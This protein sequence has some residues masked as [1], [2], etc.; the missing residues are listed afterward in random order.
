MSFAIKP[1]D[2]LASGIAAGRRIADCITKLSAQDSG[3]LA[4]EKTLDAPRLPILQWV[5]PPPTN[6]LEPTPEDKDDRLLDVKQSE[7]VRQTNR[8]RE[9]GLS[10]Y[11]S[12]KRLPSKFATALRC[13][14]DAFRGVGGWFSSSR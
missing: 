12:F 1:R 7:A 3:G 10:F 5:E 8:K 14:D 4:P 6:L 9:T 13:T 2:R 11:L